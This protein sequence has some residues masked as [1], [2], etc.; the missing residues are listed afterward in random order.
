MTSPI[1]FNRSAA[2]TSAQNGRTDTDAGSTARAGTQADTSQEQSSLT[3]VLVQFSD[4]VRKRVDASMR[5]NMSKINESEQDLARG[6]IE[7]I[8]RRIQ[9]LKM[10]M[11]SLAG[12]SVPPGVLREIRQLA[13][14]LG[15]A[16]KTLNEGGGSGAANTGAA[17]GENQSGAV[18]NGSGDASALSGAMSASTAGET[19]SAGSDGLEADDRAAGA[20]PTAERDEDASAQEAEQLQSVAAALTERG[21][22]SQQRRA[23]AKSVQDAVRELKS[24]LAMVK[25]ASRNDDK[26]AQK[27]IQ[28]INQY[29]ADT[30][31]AVQ[32]MNMTGGGADISVDLSVGSAGNVS[33]DVQV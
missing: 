18:A 16:A 33:I 9:M 15:Q 11:M 12:Q 30:E 13:A 17:G 27:Q 4:E 22:G 29:I 6:R 26:E 3:S 21:T 28:A 31:K 1:S 23:D 32:S 19:A 25:N 24:L 10:M 8:K 5:I 2:G 20:S 7:Q 14:E